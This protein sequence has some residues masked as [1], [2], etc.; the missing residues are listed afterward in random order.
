MLMHA[1][2]SN[3]GHHA[4]RARTISAAFLNSYN[5]HFNE[6]G[7]GIFAKI[8]KDYPVDYFWGVRGVGCVGR[9]PAGQHLGEIRHVRRPPQRFAECRLHGQHA[10]DVP[11][12][13][14]VQRR[15][16]Q[17]QHA[18]DPFGRPLEFGARRRPRF[19]ITLAKVMKV[20]I[21]GAHEFDRPPTKEEA[22]DRLERTAG[23]QARAMP[24]RF[25]DQI[26]KAEA[27]YLE[28]TETKKS[29]AHGRDRH[30]A[31]R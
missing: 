16:R 22:L 14:R 20:E 26:G 30:S 9:R 6:E 29:R 31:F 24:Q 21:G 8:Y 12:R 11:R 28:E 10:A 18:D 27:E 2:K 25:L 5:D 3:D 23:P 15:V 7:H 17:P 1:C 13:T 4:P 19:L